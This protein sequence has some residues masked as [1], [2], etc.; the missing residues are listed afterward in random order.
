MAS[1]AYPYH[2]MKKFIPI[3]CY[4]RAKNWATTKWYFLENG[5]EGLMKSFVKALALQLLSHVLNFQLN[6]CVLQYFTTN[7]SISES[8]ILNSNV[9][10]SEWI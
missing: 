9:Y 10:I 8:T 1:D 3:P 5:E 6:C 4:N 7:F 2:D